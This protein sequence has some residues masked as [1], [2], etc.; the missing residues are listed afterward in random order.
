MM[1][2][3]IIIV[4]TELLAVVSSGTTALLQVLL[5]CAWLNGR[6]PQFA[7]SL[8]PLIAQ[9]RVVQQQHK[10][11]EK[12]ICPGELARLV[13]HLHELD[14]KLDSL[15]NDLDVLRQRVALAA[16]RRDAPSR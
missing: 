10:A 2:R 12:V 15:C 7:T 13:L 4:A 5:F 11:L 16:W 3:R 1:T 6:N 14:G 9:L 8:A